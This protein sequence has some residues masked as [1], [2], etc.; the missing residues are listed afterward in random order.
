MGTNYYIKA[1]N[2]CP[3]CGASH[4]CKQGIHIGKSSYGWQFTFAWNDG[5]FYKNLDEMREWTKGKQIFDEYN[6]QM[7]YA[8][9][10]KMVQGK[11]DGIDHAQYNRDK[12]EPADAYGHIVDGVY[13][14]DGEFS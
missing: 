3:D 12:G 2:Q 6:R 9:F 10:W 13:F 14:M 8:K 1:P 7:S 5:A 11:M 4:I